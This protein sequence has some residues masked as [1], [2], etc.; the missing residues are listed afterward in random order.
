MS[1]AAIL[2]FARPC[3]GFRY[4]TLSVLSSLFNDF[5]AIKQGVSRYFELTC[6][7]SYSYSPWHLDLF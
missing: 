4:R 6:L 5:N 3:V 2:N 7:R 1:S